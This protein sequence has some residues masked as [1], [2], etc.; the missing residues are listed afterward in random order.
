MNIFINQV[1]KGKTKLVISQIEDPSIEENLNEMLC[2]ANDIKQLYS[3]GKISL[4]KASYNLKP[5]K[6][7][8]NNISELVSNISG[9]PQRLFCAKTFLEQQENPDEE[10]NCFELQ[11]ANCF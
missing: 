3:E 4:E 7:I 1:S 10:R 8:Y 2:R 9:E 5:Y 11:C 6:K